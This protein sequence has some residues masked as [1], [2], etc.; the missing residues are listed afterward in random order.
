MTRWCALFALL[1]LAASGVVSPAIG[2]YKAEFK[3]SLVVGPRRSPSTTS[4]CARW[5]PTW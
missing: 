1:L 3:N 4:G 5:A 2:Q